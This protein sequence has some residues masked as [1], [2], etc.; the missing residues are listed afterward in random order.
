M[1]KDIFLIYAIIIPLGMI[2]VHLT[3]YIK[4]EIELRRM[5]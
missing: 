1:I 4:D 3:R 5:K 2:T